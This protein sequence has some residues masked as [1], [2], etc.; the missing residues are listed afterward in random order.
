[1]ILRILY[2][3][4]GQICRLDGT[5]AIVQ[6]A[7][8]RESWRRRWPDIREASKNANGGKLMVVSERLENE[9]LS[10]M[11]LRFTSSFPLIMWI[12]ISYLVFDFSFPDL[13]KPIISFDIIILL[14][15]IWYDKACK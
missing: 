9:R 15:H 7:V 13:L 12:K 14:H 1:M 11:S 10:A 8:S 5:L 3:H 2:C 6:L 4:G